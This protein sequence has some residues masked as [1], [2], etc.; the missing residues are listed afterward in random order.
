MPAVRLEEGAAQREVEE[1]EIGGRPGRDPPAWTPRVLGRPEEEVQGRRGL[2][3][4][5]RS[6]PQ[7]RWPPGARSP[8]GWPPRGRR[9]RTARR[10]CRRPPP[11]PPARRHSGRGRADRGTRLRRDTRSPRAARKAGWVTTVRDSACRE[12]TASS[13]TTDACSTRSPGN[14]A[15]GAPGGQGQEESGPADTVHRHG[16]AGPMGAGEP[17][18]HLPSSEGKA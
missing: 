8:T 18:G 5:V 1:A 9:G 7:R 2:Q 15:H 10:C 6:D 4:P 16:P 13:G 3:S 11:R 14:A 17:L 12:A